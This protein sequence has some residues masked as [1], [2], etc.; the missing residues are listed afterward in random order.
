MTEHSAHSIP[1]Q[2]SIVGLDN[3]SP[4]LEELPLELTRSSQTIHQSRPST[5]PSSL[6]S[7]SGFNIEDLIGSPKP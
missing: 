5:K 1:S 7:H 6:K 3:S 2:H 4:Q